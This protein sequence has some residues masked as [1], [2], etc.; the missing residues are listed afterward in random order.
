M[1]AA[2]CACLVWLRWFGRTVEWQVFGSRQQNLR[3]AWT[4]RTLYGSQD[5]RVCKQEQRWYD[6]EPPGECISGSS[7]CNPATGLASN[8]IDENLKSFKKEISTSDRAR[9]RQT[10]ILDDHLSFLD[11]TKDSRKSHPFLFVKRA[12]TMFNHRQW[13]YDSERCDGCISYILNCSGCNCT[14]I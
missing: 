14:C 13:H 2:S 9:R 4:P 12:L 7:Y 1:A 6:L 3:E 10:H 11:H 5:S 8:P